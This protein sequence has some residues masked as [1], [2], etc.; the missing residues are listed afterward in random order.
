MEKLLLIGGGGHCK[1]VIDAVNKMGVFEISGIIDI[2]EKIGLKVSSIPIIGSDEELIKIVSSLHIKKCIITA[3]SVGETLLRTRLVKLS[4]NAGL[5]F[6]NIIHPSAIISEN[7]ILGK[8]NFVSAGAIINSETI[9]GDHCII[10]TGA[11]IEHDCKIGDF[12]HISPKALLCG[13]VKI[14]NNS[15]IGAGTCVIQNVAVGSNT[16]IGIGSVVTKT[17][18]SNIVAYGNPCKPKT[19]GN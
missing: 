11:V 15:H 2:K 7:S 4:E 16:I 14:G 5:E 8:G 1:V 9:I 6:V 12:V 18:E 19:N 13:G 17:V 3:G 10:N